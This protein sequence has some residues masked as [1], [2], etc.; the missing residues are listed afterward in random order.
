MGLT[1]I[2]PFDPIPSDRRELIFASGAS[3]SSGTSRNVLLFGNKTSSG[4][5]TV[6]IITTPILDDSDCIARFGRRS[7]LY[8]MYRKYVV[9]D[10]QATIYGI[11]PTEGSG[12]A[13]VTFTF[14]TNANAASTVI[15][16]FIG[17]TIEVPVASG[18]TPTIVGDAVAAAI[19]KASEGSWPATAADTTGACLVTASN[20]GPR[21]DLLLGSD[22]NHGMRMRFSVSCGMTVTK[23]SLTGGGADDDFTAAYAQMR[24][25]EY[26]YQVSP[27]HALTTVT[28]TDNGIGEH[29]NNLVQAALP[30]EGKVQVGFFGLQGTQAQATA[31]AI[32]SAANSVYGRFFHQHGSDWSPGMI[33]AHHAAVV[34]SQE[35]AHPAQ[36]INGYTNT[37][38][39]V[40]QMPAPY[41]KSEVPTQTEIRADLNNG[42]CPIALN[43]AGSPY[44]VRHVTSR[45]LNAQGNNDYRAREGHV[46]SVVEF[47]WETV[48]A[49]WST[50][51]Q[52]F[53]DNDPAAG[54]K[55]KTRTSTPSQL[56]LIIFGVIDDLTADNPL[57]IYQGPI[58]SP[59]KVT[60]MKRSCLVTKAG[61]GK[62]SAD[63]SIFAVEHLIGS[64]TT[65]R[66]TSPA[67]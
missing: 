33:A 9:V 8:N 31:V 37:D 44:L 35:I 63:V 14:A 28:S 21:G 36:N 34:R 61:A 43:K 25:G 58:L 11:A 2:D 24:N 38:S 67:Y 47:F 49:R 42:V 51:K 7:E 52:P 40:Y 5:E 39:T 45:S 29:I 65:V 48:L 19:N 6:D 32:S 26:Y 15:V 1:G 23:G 64:E 46:T 17:E 60:D 13:S 20:L 30:A 50:Q 41:L 53:V 16:D 27:K 3:N 57:G 12:A 18:D 59:S 66:E 10:P 56:R 22:A 54:Q 4:S 55:P 62:L